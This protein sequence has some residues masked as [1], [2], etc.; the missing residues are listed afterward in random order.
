MVNVLRCFLICISFCHVSLLNKMNSL[1][2]YFQ[3]LLTLQFSVI[4]SLALFP[5]C[6]LT[7]LYFCICLPYWTADANLSIVSVTKY[8]QTGLSMLIFWNNLLHFWHSV[9][10]SK[11]NI[12][13]GCQPKILHLL[14]LVSCLHLKKYLG[15][16][17]WEL[18]SA[19]YNCF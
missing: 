3:V 5:F 1:G 15:W 9:R 7:V 2:L 4:Q 6:P 16:I 13:C 17:L 14:W 8:F 12:V 11:I 10:V 19:L 18:Y